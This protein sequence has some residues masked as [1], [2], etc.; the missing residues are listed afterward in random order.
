[1]KKIH[2][3]LFLVG[4][5][6]S[7]EKQEIPQQEESFDPVKKPYFEEI[8]IQDL[9]WGVLHSV[10]TR[11]SDKSRE[12]T[13]FPFGKIL[14]DIPAKKIINHEGDVT[15]TMVLENVKNEYITSPSTFYFDNIVIH[16]KDKGENF[17]LVL[18][19]IPTL[20]WNNNSRDFANFSGTIIF[21]LPTGEKI[22]AVNLTGEDI[23][24]GIS[25]SN[26]KAECALVMYEEKTVCTYL[27][28][29]GSLEPGDERCTITYNYK[30]ECTMGSDGTGDFTND[31][32]PDEPDG[33]PRTGGTTAPTY[34]EP[35]VDKI[36]TDQLNNP[37]VKNII[38]ELQ[39]KDSHS[40]VIP[41][42]G[43]EA[44]HLSQ[45]ILDLFK[46]ASNLKLTFKIDNLGNV[47]AKTNAD[48]LA[49]EYTITLDDSYVQNATQLAI[50]RTLIHE[51]VHAWLSYLNQ[52]PP[53]D[54][55]TELLT[56]LQSNG[57]DYEAAQHMLMADYA[58]AL[59]SSLAAW[60]DY[61]LVDSTTINQFNYYNA[62]SFSGEMLNSTGFNSLS[63]SEQQMVIDANKKE[64]DAVTPSAHDAKGSKCPS[65]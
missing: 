50:A 33:L 35:E 41:E 44:S 53:S 36:D 11:D 61:R 13:N 18:R 22:N 24:E 46:N 43:T 14:K 63:S 29:P 3:Y 64:G 30:W 49:G 7:C 65:Q 31:P 56:Y 20:H 9:P 32:A 57:Y 45:I 62:L 34:P 8:Q 4:I 47:N 6:I 1:M 21:Y 15:Y 26:R 54:L 17:V 28:E 42:L 12:E 40:S 52:Q 60:D 16:E 25:K 48:V 55:K 5:T 19:Y 58:P 51:T 10:D 38:N 59:A 39:E 23:Y 27:S 37:C 2:L